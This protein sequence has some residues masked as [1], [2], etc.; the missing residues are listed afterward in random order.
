MTFLRPRHVLA[1]LQFG[2]V[3]ATI[4]A[5][6]VASRGDRKGVLV[7]NLL[8]RFFIVCHARS[9]WGDADHRSLLSILL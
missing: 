3:A 4:A 1:S 6:I 2:T 8:L 5:A 9:I 7:E